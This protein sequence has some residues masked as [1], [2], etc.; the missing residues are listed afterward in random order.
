MCGELTYRIVNSGTNTEPD[1][2]SFNSA[3]GLIE[4]A[5]DV[6]S[7]SGVINLTM[8]IALANYSSDVKYLSNFQ[9]S[10]ISTSD[11]AFDVITFANDFDEESYTFTVPVTT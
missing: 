10:I 6:N 1:Y 2:I 11:C 5:P 8:E 4:L 9:I 7:P 3:T